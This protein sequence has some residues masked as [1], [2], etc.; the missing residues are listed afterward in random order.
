MY[1]CTFHIITTDLESC[2]LQVSNV[3]MVIIGFAQTFL[4]ALYVVCYL[5]KF[6]HGSMHYCCFCLLF[7]WLGL[8]LREK[9]HRRSPHI[10]IAVFTLK[11]M[12]KPEKMNLHAHAAKNVFVIIN[13]RP[14]K[15]EGNFS[16][17]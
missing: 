10:G 11:W 7:P 1:L 16:R 17:K 4:A 14:H 6:K 3:C 15:N 9:V 5:L 8:Y 12:A 13:N 2:P